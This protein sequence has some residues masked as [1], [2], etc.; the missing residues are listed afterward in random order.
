MSKKLFISLTPLF[1]VVA[2]AMS[3]AAAQAANNPPDTPHVHW[4]SQ[5]PAAA[6]RLGEP[7]GSPERIATLSWGTLQLA[8]EKK[9]PITCENVG[10][11]DVYNPGPFGEGAGKGREAPNGKDETESFAPYDC[12]DEECPAVAGLELRV[13]GEGLPWPSELEEAVVGG[14]RVIR[15][16]SKE[17]QVTII[18][19]VAGKYEGYPETP[20]LVA[21]PTECAGPNTEAVKAKS[22]GESDPELINGTSATVQ[23]R[24]K[25]TGEP[26]H[27]E[28]GTE[29]EPN[30]GTTTE[31]LKTIT[32]EK[33]ALYTSD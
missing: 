22:N 21:P 15:D 20:A 13:L 24:A 17:V 9:A 28:C 26:D 6:T 32:Y 29:A 33:G 18:C 30:K 16:V 31:T 14:K 4:F 10:G 11:G 2:F 1:A 19:V 8:S 23:S 25:F 5:S 12:T 7:G 27:L 3:A